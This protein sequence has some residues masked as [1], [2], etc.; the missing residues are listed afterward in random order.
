[1]Y[2]K[3]RAEGFGAEVR[4]RILIGTYVLSAGYYDAYYLRAQKVRRLILKDF[5]DAWAQC[6]AILTPTT[7]EPGFGLG[8]VSDP[9]SMYL[10]DVYTVTVNL[11]GLPGISVPIGLSANGL[12]LGLQLIGKP[13]GEADLLCAAEVLES[14]SGFDAKPSRWW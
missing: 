9:I 11:A 7:P 3:T 2:E 4:R 1:M 6:D 14:R 8:E 12:P 5:E 13:W 10:Q